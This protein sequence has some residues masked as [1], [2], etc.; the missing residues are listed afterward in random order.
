MNL[1]LY[2][3]ILGIFDFKNMSFSALLLIKIA[4]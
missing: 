1:L 2:A 3:Y 4:I